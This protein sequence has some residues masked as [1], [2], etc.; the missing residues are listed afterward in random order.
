M[1]WGAFVGAELVGF[2]TGEYG[3]GYWSETGPG[4]DAVMFINEFVVNPEQRGKNIGKY[5]T[6]ISVD[7]R[8]GIFG[9]DPKVK[10]MYTTFHIDNMGSR[11]AFIKGGAYREVMTY[12]DALRER[13]TTVAK[14]P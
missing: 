5:L 9:I 11:T 6:K 12:D 3:G 8:L 7:S 10:E 2:I 13:K 1:V 14:Y 4:K